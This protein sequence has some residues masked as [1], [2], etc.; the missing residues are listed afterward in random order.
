MA[1]LNSMM[2][3]VNEQ[4]GPFG[5]LIVVGVLG[6]IL[7]ALTIPLLIRESKD[8][9]DKLKKTNDAAQR[10]GTKVNL[11]SGKHNKK[12][13]RYAT[14]LEPKNE[15]ELSAI[16]LSLLQAG[17]RNRDAVRYFHIAQLGLGIGGLILGVVYFMLFMSDTGASTQDT[18][19][20]ILGPGAAGYL[21]PK[22]WVKKRKG[23]RQKLLEEGFPD[24]LDMME[25][26]VEA[27]QSIDQAMVRVAKELRTSCA[28]LAEEYEIITYQIKAGRDRALVLNE[29]AERCG[30]KD[31]GSF[32]TMLIQSQQFGTSIGAAL[33]TYSEEMR[34]KRVMRAEERANK[35]PVKMTL[36]TMGLTVP[37]LM[38]ILVGPSLVSMSNF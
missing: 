6:L 14:F 16:K 30:V 31:I 37:S 23:Q 3:F 4:L 20:Y 18:L 36:V 32:V 8:P 22:Y 12:L 13:D 1:F 7:V 2:G 38:I 34:D 24:S 35:L 15:K 5:M 11:R 25:T 33:R 27:G 28:P 9:L 19:M 21:F 29:M 17:Y 10:Q 26:C